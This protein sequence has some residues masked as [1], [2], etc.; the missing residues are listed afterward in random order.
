MDDRGNTIAEK[1]TALR[2]ELMAQTVLSRG[3]LNPGIKNLRGKIKE[4]QDQCT[5]EWDA[6]GVCMF[7][8]LEDDRTYIE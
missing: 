2:E 4:L 8:G 5:H 6:E 7:C 1:V 3:E